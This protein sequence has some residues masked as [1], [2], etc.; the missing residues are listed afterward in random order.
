LGD[1]CEN[2]PPTVK[3]SPGGQISLPTW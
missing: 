2:L 1:A 3:A